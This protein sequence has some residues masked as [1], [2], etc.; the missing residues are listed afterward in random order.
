MSLRMQDHPYTR[1]LSNKQGVK[2]GVDMEQPSAVRATM[3]F[4]RVATLLAPP[5]MPP[6]DLEVVTCPCTKQL[7][8]E[9]ICPTFPRHVTGLW[10]WHSILH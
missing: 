5:E 10:A 7:V 1:G 2:Q 3:Q 9:Q 6:Q 8:V 4:W